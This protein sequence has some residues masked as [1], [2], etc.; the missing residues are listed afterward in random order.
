MYVRAYC[1]NMGYRN[2]I[3]LF[4]MV[5]I[6]KKF[7]VGDE[8]VCSNSSDANYLSFGDM[9]LIKSI[10]YGGTH[11]TLEGSLYRGG[12]STYSID[13]FEKIK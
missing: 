7:K 1:Y 10:E 12:D 4:K 5:L 13:R 8:V 6:D 2:E 9:Y 11:V 3:W